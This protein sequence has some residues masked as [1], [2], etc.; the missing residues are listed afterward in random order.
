MAIAGFTWTDA[1]GSHDL[2]LRRPLM[3]VEPAIRRAT[4]STET[5]AGALQ[6]LKSPAAAS[7]I[8][9]E[10]RFAAAVQA[11]LDMLSS[12][13]GD[14]VTYYEE[15]G[16]S[17][18]MFPCLLVDVELG[19][20]GEVGLSPDPARFAHGEYAASVRLR[21]VDGGTWEALFG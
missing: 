20:D 19:G 6:T 8:S 15:R 4:W 2:E 9:G 12:R 18:E 7:E 13:I 17:T 21:R 1:A 5:I 11:L 16:G 10:I 3:R 14:E